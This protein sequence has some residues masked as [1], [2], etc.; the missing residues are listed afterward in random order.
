MIIGVPRERLARPGASGRQR[1]KSCTP[2]AMAAM[3]STLD[4]TIRRAPAKLGTAAAF[5]SPPLTPPRPWRARCSRNF[6]CRVGTNA[7]KVA[8]PLREER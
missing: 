5:F 6:R 4:Y 2:T 3:L 7:R 1:G 8:I